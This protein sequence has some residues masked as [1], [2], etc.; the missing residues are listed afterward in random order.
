MTGLDWVLLL[1]IVISTLLAA[2]QGFIQEVFGLA[3][4]VIG[5]VLAAWEYPRIAPW[6]AN[7]VSSIW[8]A[9]IAAFLTIF[10]GVVLLAGALA[11]IVRWAV[12]GVGLRWFDR[13]LGGAFGAVRGV[14]IAA[15]IVMAMAAFVPNSPALKNSAC[16]PYFLV[17]SRT[18]SWVA[19][20]ELREKFRQGVVI[21]RTAGEKA[22]PVLPPPKEAK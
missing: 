10:I 2:A 1:L 8:V 11:R 13:V 22:L 19:P 18:A 6:F 14:A 12:S 20:A 21:L 5:Y 4:V 15:V 9:D 7:Y 3:G 16:A 17:L